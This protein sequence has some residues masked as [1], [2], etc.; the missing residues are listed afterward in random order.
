MRE[1][2][3]FEGHEITQSRVIMIGVQHDYDQIRAA[4]APEAGLEVMAQYTRAAAA[5][6][7]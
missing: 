5:A 4:P 3:V 2:W 1:D 6:K 7:R